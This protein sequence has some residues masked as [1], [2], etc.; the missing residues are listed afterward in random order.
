MLSFEDDDDLKSGCF[1]LFFI[2]NKTKAD[3]VQ[4]M[5]GFISLSFLSGP[6]RCST[7]VN[8]FVCTCVCFCNL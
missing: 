8:R 3:V 7:S 4:V 5:T 2:C 6:G 1:F